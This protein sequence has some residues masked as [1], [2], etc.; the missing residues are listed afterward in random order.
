MRLTPQADSVNRMALEAVGV[1]LWTIY[2]GIVAAR[3]YECK[4]NLYRV[5]DEAYEPVPYP[6]VR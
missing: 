6:A 4:G 3:T 1:H 2:S 5:V